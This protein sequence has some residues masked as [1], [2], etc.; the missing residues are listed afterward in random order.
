[1][2]D[3]GNHGNTSMLYGLDK[4]V[5]EAN[6]ST[7]L[8]TALYMIRNSELPN[9]RAIPVRTLY[10]QLKEAIPTQSAYS[11]NWHMHGN[12]NKAIGA[13]MY[14]LLTGDCVLGEEPTDINSN[15]WKLWMSHKIGYETAYNLMYLKGTIPNCN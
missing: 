3:N 10:A 12:L 8:G 4:R 7:D 14:T 11:D 5:N 9:A 6:N 13:Y 15:E 1:M 2:Q